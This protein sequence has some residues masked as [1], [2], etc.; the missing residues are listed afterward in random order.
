MTYDRFLFAGFNYNV[1]VMIWRCR[2]NI[3]I[4]V[5]EQT[6]QKEYDETEVDVHGELSRIGTDETHELKTEH[7]HQGWSILFSANGHMR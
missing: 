3:K 2:L 7:T 6:R 5:F 4:Q 1:Y